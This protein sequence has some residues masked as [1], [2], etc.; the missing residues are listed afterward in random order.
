[1]DTR[2]PLKCNRNQLMFV[3]I[4]V[5]SF[6]LLCA[7]PIARSADV[8]IDVE[9]KQGQCTQY[10][11]FFTIDIENNTDQWLQIDSVNIELEDPRASDLIEVPVGEK[12]K[13]WN[14][15]M[16]YRA[17][18]NQGTAA[19][20][21]GVMALAGASQS[22]NSRSAEA[23]TDFA[24]TGLVLSTAINDRAVSRYLPPSHLL[25]V[26]YFVPPG[27]NLGRWVILQTNNS[28][29]IPYLESMKLIFNLSDGEAITKEVFFRENNRRVGGCVWQSKKKSNV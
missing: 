2:Y 23:F 17:A 21:F 25:S 1:M 22:D 13:A 4:S 19:A 9:L 12:L 27:L 16:R 29:D 20:L 15:A 11:G 28:K 10:F 26:P 14:E 5:V 3:F 7:T 6:L 8:E 18:K 24:V